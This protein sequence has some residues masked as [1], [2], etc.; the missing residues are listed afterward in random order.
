METALFLPIISVLIF[1]LAAAVLFLAFAYRQLATH[2]ERLQKQSANEHALA[3]QKSTKMLNSAFQQSQG[4]LKDSEQKAEELV[5][6]TEF[7]SASVQKE[8]DEKI[9][10]TTQKELKAYGA[11]LEAFSKDVKKTFD[12]ISSTLTAQTGKELETF[13]QTIQTQTKQ[14]ET[15]FLEEVAKN[16]QAAEQEGAAYKQE[17]I[18]KIDQKAPEIIK[19]VLEEVAPKMI[20]NKDHEELVLQ[21]LSEAKQSHVI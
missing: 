5:T 2:F 20:T 13:R 4:I 18:K 11:V 1:V 3:L 8:L 19:K 7:L 15:G 14:I 12:S 6:N 16:R 21:S 10:A 17:L 9:Q